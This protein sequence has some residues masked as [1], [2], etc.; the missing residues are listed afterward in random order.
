MTSLKNKK[1]LARRTLDAGKGRI[2]F[3]QSRL[4]DIKEAL[5]KQDIRDLKDDGAIV[6]K[7]AKG[8]KK[9]IK[10]KT[11]KGPGKVRKKVNTR[12]QDYAIMTRKLRK[13]VAEMKKQGRLSPEEIKD[14]RNKIR[15]KSFRSKAHL[16][17]HIGGLRK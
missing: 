8:R 3:V 11:R 17:Q 6:I 5:T 14:I 4:E 10:R 16:K 15:N 1:E 2:V 9:V 13:Y 12:K 7:E